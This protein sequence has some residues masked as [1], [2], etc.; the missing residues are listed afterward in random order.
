[1]TET[2]KDHRR[3]LENLKILQKIHSASA[4][5]SA[6]GINKNTWTTR[7]REPWRL[8]SYDDFHVISTYC[9]VDMSTLL[10]GKVTVG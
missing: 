6:L 7:M 1:M 9:R 3:L 2:L 5:A 8:F 10:L 4:L